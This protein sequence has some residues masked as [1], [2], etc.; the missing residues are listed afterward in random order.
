LAKTAFEPFKEVARFGGKEA[1]LPAL[2]PSPAA[3]SSLLIYS[4]YIMNVTK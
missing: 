1:L 2:V 3:E 4:V